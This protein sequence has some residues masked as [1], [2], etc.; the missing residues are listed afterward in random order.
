[1]SDSSPTI[2]RK[3]RRKAPI[4]TTSQ[5]SPK[6][7]PSKKT[8]PPSPSVQ[9][10]GVLPTSH[11]AASPSKSQSSSASQQGNV[12]LA[13]PSGAPATPGLAVPLDT[14][15]AP[16]PKKCRKRNVSQ[17]AIVPLAV[18]A[19]APATPG[20]AVPLDTV[21]APKPKK[22]SKRNG[23]SKKKVSRRQQLLQNPFLDLQAV[24]CDSDGDSVQGSQNSEDDECVPPHC[25]S[26]SFNFNSLNSHSMHFQASYGS[27]IRH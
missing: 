25:S 10:D 8:V 27:V 6:Q 2:Q 1:M 16:K 26:C 18:H 19:G 13:F 7:R 11:R 24:E 3:P 20:L 12:P 22:A 14:V 17:Q 9:I 15:A 4:I 23:R 21:A 5:D